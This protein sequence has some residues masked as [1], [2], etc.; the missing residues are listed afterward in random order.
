MSPALDYND[1][2]FLTKELGVTLTAALSGT[3]NRNDIHAWLHGQAN[4]TDDQVERL[5]FACDTFKDVS[6]SQGADMTRTWFLGANVGADEISPIEAI[7]DGRFEEVR[8]S[9]RR[10]I[11]DQWQ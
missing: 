6:K 5:N 2:V 8:I 11:E 7:R 4:P 9:A 3:R 10:M 1:L